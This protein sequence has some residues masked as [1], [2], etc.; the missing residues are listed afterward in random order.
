MN[1]TFTTMAL[2]ALLLAPHE[3]AHAQ[4][5]PSKPGRILVGVSA[6]GGVDVASR[7]IAAK[8][9]EYWGHQV[10]VD[11]R[12]GGGQIIATEIVAKAAPDGYTL[13]SCNIGTHGAGPSLFSKLPYDHIK[14]FAPI[15]LMG[16]NPMVLVVN[17]GVPAKSV[18]EFVAFT[19]ASPGK[20][21]IAYGGIG[22]S[23][24]MATEMFRLSAGV[25]VVL[26]P[27]KGGAAALVDVLGGHVQSMIDGLSTQLTAIKGARVRALAVTSAKRNAFL[28][29]TPTMIES[30]VPMEATAWYGLCAPAGVPKPILARIN[31]D[32]V[33]ALGTPDVRQRFA[34]IGLDAEPQT[35][36]QFAALIKSETAKWAKVIKDARIPQQ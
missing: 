9:T 4:A 16:T 11:N 32:V 10:V 20:I 7:V 3:N 25:N 1:R 8:L 36:G 13:L 17:P 29:D 27:Y 22:T 6:G 24:H 31:A 15:S 33:K 2:L 19:Q 28:P 18:K 14:D 5:F 34:D 35:P 23:T 30:G 26:V 12:V 21:V